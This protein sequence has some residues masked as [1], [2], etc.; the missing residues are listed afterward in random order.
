M[1]RLS[2]DGLL[3]TTFQELA[4][5]L[6][7]DRVLDNIHCRDD[8][9][10]Y[11][12][13]LTWDEKVIVINGGSSGQWLAKLLRKGPV[14][15]LTRLDD[16]RT[17]P[18]EIRGISFWRHL[19]ST[20]KRMHPG[21][22]LHGDPREM[23]VGLLRRVWGH[24]EPQEMQDAQQALRRQEQVRKLREDQ[25]RQQGKPGR[26]PLTAG[27]KPRASDYWVYFQ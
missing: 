7:M 27:A 18:I 17:R 14:L 23:L 8:L 10:T 4:T 9:V 11:F 12:K 2:I 19:I 6:K 16:D 25:K 24:G 22:R 26:F 20:L 15:N 13:G 5:A 1:N 21:F 3:L